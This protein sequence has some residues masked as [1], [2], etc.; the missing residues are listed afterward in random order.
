MHSIMFVVARVAEQGMVYQRVP[1]GMGAR[2]TKGDRLPIPWR[3]R[4]HRSIVVAVATVFVVLPRGKDNQRIGCTL[5]PQRAIHEQ[6][7]P[8]GELDNHPSLDQQHRWVLDH[9]VASDHIG[10]VGVVPN[11]TAIAGVTPPDLQSI[12]AVVQQHVAADR[13]I[14]THVGTESIPGVVLK[15]GMDHLG[16]GTLDV[17]CAH[18]MHSIMFVVARVAEQGIRDL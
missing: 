13:R 1:A 12:P 9:H 4:T 3:R 7:L 6:P 17:H 11:A 15:G 18:V 8:L 2:L 16:R 5:H 14:G 10:N